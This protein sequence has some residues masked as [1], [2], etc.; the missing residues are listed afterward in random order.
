MRNRP[1]LTTVEALQTRNLAD[2]NPTQ[3]DSLN[4]KVRNHQFLR[5]LSQV[6]S[7]HCNYYTDLFCDGSNGKSNAINP[8][9]P[10][11]APLTQIGTEDPDFW[12]K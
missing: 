1:E 11:T 8:I 9:T 12:P 6:F 10:I 2:S 5:L 7:I 3:N 4:S